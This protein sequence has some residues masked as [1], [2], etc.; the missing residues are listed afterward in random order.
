MAN[1]GDEDLRAY[2]DR[3]VEVTLDWQASL[4]ELLQ[5]M[6]CPDNDGGE[7][8]P[9]PVQAQA[10]EVYTYRRAVRCQNLQYGEPC[11]TFTQPIAP[12]D[13]GDIPI[14]HDDESNTKLI[15]TIAEL[16]ET[17]KELQTEIQTQREE[18]ALLRDALLNCEACKPG[19][20]SRFGR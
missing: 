4:L 7:R 5:K 18:T 12:P 16:I 14:L 9:N 11:P 13:R 1:S 19:R 20:N 15:K 8:D 2:H 10:N 17:I 6:G 3:H